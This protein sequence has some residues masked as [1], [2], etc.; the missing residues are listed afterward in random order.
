M[1]YDWS[2]FEVVRLYFFTFWRVII[3]S[4]LNFQQY[5]QGVTLTIFWA[6][7]ISGNSHLRQQSGG[8]AIAPAQPCAKVTCFN[9]SEN[10]S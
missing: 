10:Q 9:V 8:R 2:Y 7:K 3:S 4:F 6:V 5:F 1:K